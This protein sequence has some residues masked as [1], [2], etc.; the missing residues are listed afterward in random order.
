MQAQQQKKFKRPPPAVQYVVEDTAQSVLMTPLVNEDR[1]YSQLELGKNRNNA[2]APLNLSK[3]WV[4]HT[5]CGHQ[6]YVK[7]YGQKYKDIVASNSN[8]DVGNCSVCWKFRKT[9]RNLVSAAKYYIE[10]YQTVFRYMQENQGYL[11]FDDM[12]I[13]RIYNTWLNLEIYSQ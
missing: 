4:T 8:Y 11:T 3:V 5:N 6:Y 2:F 13:E 7:M 9:P 12:Q 10:A 1:P